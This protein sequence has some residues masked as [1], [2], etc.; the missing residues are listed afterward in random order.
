[1]GLHQRERSGLGL[2]KSL[3]VPPKGMHGYRKFIFIVAAE[4]DN[5][6]R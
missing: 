1:M 6:N 3:V 4:I 5:E 2:S